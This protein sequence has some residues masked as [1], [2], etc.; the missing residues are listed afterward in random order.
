MNRREYEDL[1][2]LFRGY[3]TK[4]DKHDIG[5]LRSTRR[6]LVCKYIVLNFLSQQQPLN[7]SR[8]PNVAQ[9]YSNWQRKRTLRSSAVSP[10]KAS[11]TSSLLADLKYCGFFEPLNQGEL[12]GKEL[13]KVLCDSLR[14]HVLAETVPIGHT[15][16]WYRLSTLASLYYVSRS[17]GTKYTTM[18]HTIRQGFVGR[19]PDGEL[20][21]SEREFLASTRRRD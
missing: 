10:N 4:Y 18:S 12:E 1:V 3:L 21:E 8:S 14:A 13:E 2:S 7:S 11:F 16:L 20:V 6:K 17:T 19:L 9:V 15:I 5:A